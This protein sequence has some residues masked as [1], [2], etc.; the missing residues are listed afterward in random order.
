M[1]AADGREDPPLIERLRTEPQAFDPLQALL[2]LE[3]HAA[4]EAARDRA[5]RA[6]PVGRDAHPQQEV[7]RFVSETA[8]AF[9]PSELTFY[10]EQPDAE[11]RLGVSFIGLH[12]PSGVMPQAYSE[13]IQARIREKDTSLASFF[14]LFLHRSASFF[15]RA[16][17]KYRLTAQTPPDERARD[18]L[19]AE[20]GISGLIDALIGF[21]TEGLKARLATPHAALRFY[22]GALAGNPRSAVVLE[23]LLSDYFGESIRVDTFVPHWHRL[24]RSERTRLVPGGF[25]RL[26][27]EAVIGEKI[28]RPEGAYRIELGPLTYARFRMFLPDREPLRQLVHF[29]R[30]FTGEALYFDVRLS[31]KKEDVPP[32]KLGDWGG[33]DGPRLGWN[34]WVSSLPAVKDKADTL[35]SCDRVA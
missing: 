12:G 10:R 3:R 32:L 19:P 17:T 33:G 22:A 1:A 29:A 28:M 14:D 2:I 30:L 4:H 6:A 5:A 15:M 7:V 24:P 16:W 23:S 13:L 25:C 21:S 27:D 26:G 34:T 8:L 11:V 35:L 18:V 9:P 31:L 20:A